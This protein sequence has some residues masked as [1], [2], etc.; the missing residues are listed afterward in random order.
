M[1]GR[2]IEE[3]EEE[4]ADDHPVVEVSPE[5]DIESLLDGLEELEQ[6]LQQIQQT[7]DVSEHDLV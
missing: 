3:E 6:V 5:D 2:Q 1:W 4:P 7:E